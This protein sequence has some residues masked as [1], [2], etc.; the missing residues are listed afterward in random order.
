MS[1]EIYKS[2][3]L[4]AEATE[5]YL[6]DLFNDAN[7]QGYWR[8]ES[9]G[10]DSSS[11]GY[12]LTG[13]AP[14]FTTGKFGNGGDFES[15]SSQYLSI[16]DASCPNLEIS[17]S[18]TVSLWF[19]PESIS[20]QVLFAKVAG[21]AGMQIFFDT[22]YVQFYV[23]GLTTNEFVNYTQG[24]IAGN[25]YHIVGRY[26]SVAGELSIFING[27]KTTVSASG[28]STD[29]NGVFYIGRNDAGNY[30]DGIID[31]V[32]I[33]DRALTDAEVISLYGSG[34]RAYYRLEADGSDELGNYDLQESNNSTKLLVHFNG[35]DAATA[36]KA[37][38]SNQTLTFAG[39][40][41]LDTA[42]Y[43]FGV[44]SLLLDGTG[45][46]VTVPDSADWDLGLTWTIDTWVRFS[47]ITH[48]QGICGQWEDTNN[49][50]FFSWHTNGNLYFI[51]FV[52]GI[53][54]TPNVTTW[55]PSQDTWYHVALVCNAGVVDFYIDGVKK[56]KTVSND[57][58]S[59][60]TLSAPFAIG[61]GGDGSGSTS[62][63]F[64]GWIDE[65]RLVKG[66]AKWTSNFTPPTSEY[67][68][69]ETT[70][71]FDTGE[72]SN[73]VDF[74]SANSTDFLSIE[75]DLG[76]GRHPQ[77]ISMWVKCNAEIASGEWVF[78]SSNDGANDD[79]LEIGYQYNSGTLRV[80]AGYAKNGVSFPDVMYYEVEL[81][82]ANWHHIVATWDGAAITEL[83]VD[84]VSR[85]TGAPTI[86]SGSCGIG[87]V[88]CIGKRGHNDYG[89]P[90]VK[91][92]DISIWDR[93]L[94][95]AEIAWIYNNT[96]YK[97]DLGTGVFN[98]SGV[99]ADFQTNFNA[100]LGTGSFSL[101]GINADFTVQQREVVILVNSV[102]ISD[103]VLFDTLHVRN[104]LYSDP[105]TAN[106][107]IIRSSSKS[108]NPQAG[109]E[110]EIQ[111]T[112]LTIFKGL[113]ISIEK[114]MK[115][116]QESY[117]LE[118]KDW[119]EELAN[120][121]IDSEYNNETVEAII[122]DIFTDA[123]LSS[124]D[125]TTHV[126]D[127]TN[128]A[129][130][131]FDNIS[132]SSALDRL[133]QLSNKNWYVSPDKEIY[134]FSD[135]VISAPFDIN[136]TNGNAIFSSVEVSEDYTQLRNDVT[137]KGKGVA[138][139]N[140]T[141]ATSISSYGLRQYFE[142]DNDV[143]ATNEATQKAN[144]ILSAYKDPIKII[145]F[146]TKKN[147]LFSGQQIDIVSAIRGIN[148]TV[149]I[150]TVNFKAES[151][152]RFVYEVK[153]TTR[154]LGKIEDLFKQ[155]ADNPDI[156]PA[157]GDQGVLQNIEFTA[158]D[159]ETI[160][161]SSGSIRT[162][163]GTVYSIDANASETLTADH[164]IYFDPAT[165]TTE[166]QIS[167]TFSDGIGGGKIPLCYATK[168]A[169]ATKGASIF[170]VSFGQK[171][172]LDGSV[173]ITDRSVIADNI[174]ANSITANEIAANTI[175]A[176]EIAA[177][178]ITA[179][180]MSVS[181]LSA[182]TAYMGTLNL[183]NTTTGSNL[184]LDATNRRIA[185][186]YG[187]DTVAY[188]YADSS[189]DLRI[190]ADNSI[191]LSATGAGDFIYLEANDIY[192]TSNAMYFTCS[193]D[194]YINAADTVIIN[195]NKQDSGDQ[196]Y[197][198]EDSGNVLTLTTGK[199]AYFADDVH[200]GGDLSK[201]GG[202][203]RI[204]HPLKP[205]THFL[206]HSFVEA[207]ERL[208]IYKGRGLTVN[209]K[210]TIELP[211]YFEALNTNIEYNLTPIGI[212]ANLW[213]SKEYQ[214]NKV[215]V[216]SNVDCEFSWI[217]YGVRKDPYALAKPMEVE[218]EK[219]I[220]GYLYPE[221][222]G[223]TQNLNDK[224]RSENIRRKLRGEELLPMHNKKGFIKPKLRSKIDDDAL[225]ILDDEVK[226]KLIK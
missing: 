141:D 81:G 48:L 213:V 55:S 60:P 215:E 203:F 59:Y 74:G 32:A 97:E 67:T 185:W 184:R 61:V 214:N 6:S 77:T 21:T 193:S 22:T 204:D 112:G 164:V 120:I 191:Y 130:V 105:D 102:D 183:V 195:Y 91:I 110:I 223:E 26:D 13:T 45:D 189:G 174:A 84:G 222:Y 121:I 124:Y 147:G 209:G 108:Y 160:Q 47:D 180:R 92:D 197:I 143:T 146:Q 7:L 95:D 167:T 36:Y 163:D 80:Y 179:D 8:L 23:D 190:D 19:K 202:S 211:D 196:F 188:A 9:D 131:V 212:N 187:T 206:F 205:E 194:W 113:L 166:L 78:Y 53:E 221:L 42:Q 135:S 217:I 89:Y 58:T 123:N 103:E 127:T 210:F 41:Q 86:G 111:D 126:S 132:V 118:F 72:F 158:I 33:L 56:T 88:V 114:R 28:S 31:D 98:L 1:V 142:I 70:L 198:D 66:E 156:T 162:S 148:E 168:S 94:L 64:K 171:I 170:P 79:G 181:T 71:S 218:V 63:M 69:N 29:S 150:E 43:K 76:L 82:T 224:I 145:S 216:A 144:A 176:N 57:L 83:W 172:Q 50:M 104:N 4:T 153:A 182:I 3:L 201:G 15:G 54:Q 2:A 51:R 11:N 116:F 106:F 10:T 139:V 40:A 25:W 100:E 128:I 165:S 208:N 125:G 133:A 30:A 186:I 136:D 155:A 157:L 101:T 16:A 37:E 39:N 137:V 117:F 207:P 38:I 119:N 200:V 178:T 225:K 122:E 18:R 46:W 5:F 27:N 49:F 173:H 65:F 44:S 161:W 226:D 17:G 85:D 93:V 134:F 73:A 219:N 199:D 149:N 138:A 154:R 159:D 35:A 20:L 68:F 87:D 34:L 169:I 192:Y 175:T 24:L 12:T 129:R 96:A 109:D 140:V 14:T 177:S 151:E 152:T 62:Y 99:N 115:G 75:N 52:G 90:S 107:E 220:K